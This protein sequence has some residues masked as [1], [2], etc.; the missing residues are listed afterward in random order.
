MMRSTRS[1]ER[2]RATPYAMSRQGQKRLASWLSL[3]L[4]RVGR[5]RPPAPNQQQV[6]ATLPS[7]ASA[8]LPAPLAQLLD[9]RPVKDAD[10]VRR[11]DDGVQ[12]HQSSTAAKQ[13]R[14]VAPRRRRG[15]DV[16]ERGRQAD[17]NA[18]RGAIVHGVVKSI[19][20]GTAPSS[21]WAASTACSTSPMETWP[22]AVS[23]TKQKSSRSARARRQ[24]L[25]FDAEKTASRSASKQLGDDPWH[26]HLA[27]LPAGHAPVRQGHEHRRLRRVRRDRAGHR[28]PGPRLGDGL[29]QQE[30]RPVEDGLARR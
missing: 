7:S 1:R 14:A 3:E 9:T 27:A 26:R 20:E 21:T 16:G 19:T 18:A 6:R 23:A 11:Q 15:V 24:V 2:L 25:K 28:R 30:R 4:A 5:V 10:A 29:D 12:G 13:R 22:G 8:R 17:G